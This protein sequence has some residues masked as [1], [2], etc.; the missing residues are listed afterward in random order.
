MF[1]ESSGWVSWKPFTQSRDHST[2]LCWLPAEL[3]GYMV[4][5]H[6][7]VFALASRLTHQLTIID[8]TPMLNSLYNMGFIV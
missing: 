6:E 1:D 5:S 7:G 4:A 3:R 8:F 2:R